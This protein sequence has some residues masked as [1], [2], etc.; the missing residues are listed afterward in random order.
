MLTIASRLYLLSPLCFAVVISVFLLFLLTS[1]G[2][3]PNELYNE[4][5]EL[6]QNPDTVEQG[7]EVLEEFTQ[8]FPDHEHTPEALINLGIAYQG[9]K[10][11]DKAVDAYQRLIAN[12]PNTPEAYKGM[13][14]LGFLYSDELNDPEQA[15]AVLSDFIETYPDSELVES[16]V[17]LLQN[18]GKPVEE[19]DTFKNMDDTSSADNNT[20]AEQ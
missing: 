5:M 20:A 11:Y 4:G 16:A 6:I 2:K 12:H 7:A 1:C 19:W 8:R 10:E 17:V 18:V 9:L 14:M 13:F 3:T 15:K